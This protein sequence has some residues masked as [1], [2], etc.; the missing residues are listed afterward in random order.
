MYSGTDLLL[1]AEVLEALVDL[2]SQIDRGMSMRKSRERVRGH[3]RERRN[4]IV[5][6]SLN[7]IEDNMLDLAILVPVRRNT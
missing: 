7:K 2:E 3:F 5:D 4:E 6:Y 1:D